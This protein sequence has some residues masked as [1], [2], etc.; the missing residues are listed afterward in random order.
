MLA[1]VALLLAGALAGCAREPPEQALRRTV[2][3]MEEAIR[4]HDRPALMRGVDAEFVGPEGMDRAGLEQMARGYFLRYRDI[5]MQ[6]GPLAVTLY[7]DRAQVDFS[8]VL[9][10]GDGGL[11]PESG[12]VYQVRTAWRLREG[13]WRLASAQ[14]E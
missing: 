13:E 10:G 7:P 6:L 12:R 8:A 11:L 9:T 1:A 3:A 2:A 14:W 5:G 4:T